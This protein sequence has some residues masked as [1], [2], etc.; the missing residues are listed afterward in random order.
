M[1]MGGRKRKFSKKDFLDYGLELGLT[2]RQIKRV[3]IRFEKQIPKAFEL[4]KRSFL[5]GEMQEEYLELLEERYDRL[6]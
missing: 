6:Q 3:F 2:E 4:V 1:T 5:S